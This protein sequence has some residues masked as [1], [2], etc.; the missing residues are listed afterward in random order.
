MA[1]TDKIA[2]EFQEYEKRI[3]RLKKAEA[4]LAALGTPE[5]RKAHRKEIA[6]IEAQLKSPKKVENVEKDIDILKK[7][8][9]YLEDARKREEKPAE[10]EGGTRS[11]VILPA[12]ITRS[13]FVRRADRKGRVRADFPGQS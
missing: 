5:W 10:K 9:K 8:L 2:G 13:L 4:E 6:I 3:E 12:G 11:S 1:E 7:N